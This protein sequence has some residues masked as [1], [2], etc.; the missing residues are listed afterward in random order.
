MFPSFKVI[1]CVNHAI[2]S[3][4]FELMVFEILDNVREVKVKGSIKSSSK[5]LSM[6]KFINSGLL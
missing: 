5:D 3:K 2:I 6:L 4:M 1:R